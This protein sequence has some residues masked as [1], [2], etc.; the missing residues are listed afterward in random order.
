MKVESAESF[1]SSDCSTSLL[2]CFMAFIE[3]RGSLP[4][5]WILLPDVFLKIIRLVFFG[6]MLNIRDNQFSRKIDA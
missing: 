5:T 3:G 1:P 2:S 4:S 6:R